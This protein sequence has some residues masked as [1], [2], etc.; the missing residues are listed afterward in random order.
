MQ[1]LLI[2]GIPMFEI[3]TMNWDVPESEGWWLFGLPLDEDVAPVQVAVLKLAGLL[4]Y[5]KHH[6]TLRQS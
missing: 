6:G 4:R 3:V 5:G 1:S 2:W